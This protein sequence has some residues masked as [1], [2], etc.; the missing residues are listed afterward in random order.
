MLIEY[1]YLK[2][3]TDTTLEF[4]CLNLKSGSAGSM[5]WLCCAVTSRAL[6]HCRADANCNKQ[7]PGHLVFVGL[8]KGLIVLCKFLKHKPFDLFFSFLTY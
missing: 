2:S 7:C 4:V 3:G 8:L 1:Q 5:T 6:S